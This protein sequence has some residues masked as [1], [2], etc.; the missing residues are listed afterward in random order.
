MHRPQGSLLKP[1]NIENPGG[2]QLIQV[3]LQN[4]HK[5]WDAKIKLQ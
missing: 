4:G 2:N 1:E 5:N 3:Q